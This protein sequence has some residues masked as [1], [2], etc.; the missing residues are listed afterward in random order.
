MA[1]EPTTGSLSLAVDQLNDPSREG[2]AYQMQFV[3]NVLRQVERSD[4]AYRS[5]SRAPLDNLF[6]SCGRPVVVNL[7]APDAAIP[8]AVRAFR[9]L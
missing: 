4:P 1:G 9:A 6:V 2:C 5:R 8:A 3:E 7:R